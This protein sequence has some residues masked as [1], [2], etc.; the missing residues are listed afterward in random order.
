MLNLTHKEDGDGVK[1]KGDVASTVRMI[2]NERLL[3]Q[4]RCLGS[5]VG[6]YGE[7]EPSRLGGAK[8]YGSPCAAAIK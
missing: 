3:N 4:E 8:E 6:P 2:R 5:E 7:A 1:G